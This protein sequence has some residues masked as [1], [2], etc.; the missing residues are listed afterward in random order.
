LEG[1]TPRPGIREQN[2]PLSDSCTAAKA[3]TR[4]PRRHVREMLR[5]G[6]LDEAVPAELLD[7]RVEALARIIASN[8][9][10]AVRGMKRTSTRSRAT[11]STKPPPREPARRQSAGTQRRLCRETS[12]AV[13]RRG[14][15]FRNR[16]SFCR[17]PE[18]GTHAATPT[19]LPIRILQ[20][21]PAVYLHLT[22]KRCCEQKIHLAVANVWICC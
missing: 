15:P 21:C 7:A 10:I 4:S 19:M 16:S 11:S 18:I 14:P 3:P 1:L 20:L 17:A 5:I 8:A 12:A 13:L 22:P 2:L 9:P 6:Y